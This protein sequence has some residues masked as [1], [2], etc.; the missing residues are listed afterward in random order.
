MVSIY[1]SFKVLLYMY[2]T[3]TTLGRIIY[4]NVLSTFVYCRLSKSVLSSICMKLLNLM[5]YLM[6]KVNY[7][8]CIPL[9][10]IRLSVRHLLLP[11]LLSRFITRKICMF[12]QKMVQLTI[13]LKNTY[14]T[15]QLKIQQSQINAYFDT[16]NSMSSG[17]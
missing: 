16:I 4:L 13:L 10:D 6:A 5:V 11:F 7:S 14:Q 15:I 1:T 12:N 2:V 8:I 9:V 17:K 3:F